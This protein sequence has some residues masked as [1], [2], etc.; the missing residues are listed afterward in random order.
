M[1]GNDLS[2]F[3]PEILKDCAAKGKGKVG[4]I[5]IVKDL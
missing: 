3:F 2:F 5:Y 1:M 4:I